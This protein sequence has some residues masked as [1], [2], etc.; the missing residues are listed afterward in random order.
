[1]LRFPTFTTAIYD[2]Y[3]A[4]FNGPGA[5]MLAGVLVL[6]CLVLLLAEIRLRGRRGYARLGRG[7]ARPAPAGRL[8]RL[9]G[10]ARGPGRRS[11]SSRSVVPLASLG[12][13]MAAGGLDRLR[14]GPWPPPP[15]T[16]ALAAAAAA[17]DDRHGAAHRLARRPRPGPGSTRGAGHLP[18]QL[19]ARASWSP[20]AGHPE[21][22]GP[23][24]ALPDVPA[25]LAAYAILFLPRAVVTVGRRSR[26]RRRLYDDVAAS[27]GSAALDRLRRVT[28]PL[29]RP[30]SAPAPRWSSS[31]SSPS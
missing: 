23:A 5:T 4:T 17:V 12:Y 7:A 16:L 2:Q 13:W 1:M 11:S 22:P 24:L 21:H 30:A 26:R 9:T 27:L 20:G 28:L 3:R 25:L 29:I 18:R 6:L 10:R 8:G 19:P 31:P 15:A 14:R